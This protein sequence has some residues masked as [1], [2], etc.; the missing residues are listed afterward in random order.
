MLSMAELSCASERYFVI[1]YAKIGSTLRYE[2]AR[3]KVFAKCASC[4]QGTQLNAQEPLHNMLTY[5]CDYW[6]EILDASLK[7][8]NG[9]RAYPV[10]QTGRSFRL[11]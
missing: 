2:N 7:G 9:R 1:G 3:D 10:C 4:Q 6:N 11:I 5:P 8:R